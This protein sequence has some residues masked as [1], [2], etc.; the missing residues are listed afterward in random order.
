MKGQITQYKIIDCRG[1]NANTFLQGQL[2]CDI[3]LCTDN[4]FQLAAHC[5]PQGRVTSLIYVIKH[6]NGFF[7]ATPADMAQT[8]FDALNRYAVFSKVTLTIEDFFL[9]GSINADFQDN[10]A[11]SQGNFYLDRQLCIYDHAPK[12][13]AD[14]S[15]LWHYHDISSG[16]PRLY[17]S[18]VDK[19][20]APRLNLGSLDAIN[21]KKGCY[22]GQ[23][24]IARLYF[25]GQLKH[26]MYLGKTS[27]QASLQPNDKLFDD[28]KKN[29]GSVIDC[30]THN[31]ETYLLAI[32]SIQEPWQAYTC[33]EELINPID[34]PYTF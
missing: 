29:I 20:V 8:T 3:R 13:N 28:T 6:T 14:I 4:K 30:I 2:T 21:Y 32:T 10:S 25:K 22:I 27:G 1:D 16:L 26:H 19:F 7:L 12:P 24:I 31:N 17:P 23:E 34:L 5:N 15:D 33:K 18:T 9:V 11:I